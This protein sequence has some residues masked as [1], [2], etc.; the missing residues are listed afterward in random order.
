MKIG[1]LVEQC[2]HGLIECPEDL[3]DIAKNHT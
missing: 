1:F 3:N 2:M